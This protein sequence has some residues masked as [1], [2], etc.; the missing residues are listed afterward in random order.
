[1]KLT[2][3]AKQILREED[4]KIVDELSAA[5]ERSFKELGSEF[6]S[7]KEEIQKDVNS[8]ETPV[9]ESIG[10]VAILG[11]ILAA[12]KLVEILVTATSKL[13]SVFKQLFTKKSAKTPEQQ[14]QIATNIIE[15]T[16]KWHK[17]YIKGLK[18]ILKVS[19]IFKKANV[20]SESEQLKQAEV[21]YYIIIAG[22]A[23][24]SGISAI[25]AFKTAFSQAGN[26][27]HFSIGSLETA[28]SSIK[29]QEVLEFLKKLK[30]M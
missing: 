15:F 18:W 19:G 21:I 13:V 4:S 5:M 22:L 16:H 10:A 14:S 11:M 9:K 1:M 12:P 26:V 25:S 20:T 2:T 27:S 7:N 3:I 8:V 23:V 17:S 29:S 24:Y 30:L 6:E 28:M